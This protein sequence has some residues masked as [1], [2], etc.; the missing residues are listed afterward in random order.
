MSSRDEGLRALACAVLH[1]AVRDMNDA[2]LSL[3]D[4]EGAR[5][6]LSGGELLSHWAAVAGLEVNAI[7][8]AAASTTGALDNEAQPQ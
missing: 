8:R 5:Y 4:R 6:F 2:A 3:R 7:R 1:Q